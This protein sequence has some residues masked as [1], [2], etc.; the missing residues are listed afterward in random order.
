MRDPGL[1]GV[2]RSNS[3]DLQKDVSGIASANALASKDSYT[4]TIENLPVKLAGK[5]NFVFQYYYVN[6]DESQSTPVLGP[7]SATYSIELDIPCIATAPTNVATAGGFYSYQVKW[8]MPT[9]ASYADTI[10]YESN[11][12]SFS[13]SSKVVYV[14]TSNQCNILTSDLLPKYVYVVHRDMFRQ[15]CIAGFVAGPITIKDPIVVDANPPTNDFTVGTATVQDDPDGLFTFNKKIL[16]NWT[17]NTD[18]S[19]YGYQIRFRRVGTTD[20]TYMSVPGRTVTS[21]YLY[22]LKAGQTYEIGV[23]TYDQF[24]NTNTSDWKSYP[25]IVIPPS[26]SLAAD[27]AIT[28]GDMKMGYGIG[29]DNANKGLYLG[30]ENYWYVIGNTTASSAARLS[31][32]GTNDKLLW[33]GTNISVTGNL[34][35]RAGSFTGNILL[36][37]TNASIYNGTINAGGNLTGNGFALNATGLKVQNGTNS[38]TLDASNGQITANAGSIGGWQLTSSGLSNN[39]ARLNSTLGTLELGGYNTDDIVHLDANDANYRMWIGKNSSATAPFKVSKSG[40]LTASGAVITGNSSFAGTLTVGTQL[41]D[42]TTIDTVK[43]KALQGITDAG[44]AAAAALVAKN[45]GDEA[46]NQ[47]IAAGQTA[48]AASDAAT[49]A[50]NAAALKMAA[51]DINTVLDLNTTIINGSRITTG[52]I[53]VAR[54][55]ITGGTAGVNGFV[56]DGNGIR[57]TSGGSQTLNISSNGTISLG[58]STNGWTVDNQ[59]IT[60]RSYYTTGYSKLILDGWNGTIEGG[61]I[62][63][64]K[65]EANTITG[66]TIT[67]TKIQTSTSGNRVELLDATTD[68]LRVIY[69]GTARGQLL[70]AA[71]S[72]ILMHAGATANANATT[73]GLF[74]A[75]PTSVTMAADSTNF[76][77]ATTSQVQMKGDQF[78]I[79][80]G[81]NGVVFAASVGQD[82]GQVYF[83]RTTTALGTLAST[84]TSSANAFLSSST[85]LIS[86]STSSRRYKTNIESIDFT[87][88]QLKSLRP[89]KFQGVADSER[90]DTAYRVGLIAE[91]VAEVV[92][93][94]DIVEY[95]EDGTPENINYNSLA[96]ILISVV[97]RILNRLDALE[98]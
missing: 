69:G 84:T 15:S 68:S 43:Q 96:P 74:L 88:D 63:A 83:Q 70:A 97:K 19:T 89:V 3:A 16:F 9:F 44:S 67:G 76:L 62:T 10:V 32:G 55:N 85:G 79:D 48:T 37:S 12:N 21:T 29:G 78:N 36:A 5:Y 60:S 7:P 45:R 26:T 95:N 1:D 13:P 17:A 77:L 65:F 8:D 22:G 58:D 4:I 81:A 87:D 24:G 82:R 25:S 14:G 20:Y 94:E 92:G 56:V 59:Y 73:Y 40:V 30:P 2:D 34:T 53:D 80:A 28:A 86:R 33:D 71:S 51:A 41:S 93:L 46:Y 18:T 23:S 49:A 38:V 91:E 11:T 52:Q 61:R 39:N 31:V 90:G 42:G 47:A 6:P 98:A 75:T 64:S 27:V 66:G 35:A 54:L 50:A 72:G 57:A